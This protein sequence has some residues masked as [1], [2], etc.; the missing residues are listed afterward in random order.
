MWYIDEGC[1]HIEAYSDCC[2]AFRINFFGKIFT[3]TIQEKTPSQN[4]DRNEE[5]KENKGNED[6]RNPSLYAFHFSH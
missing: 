6:A 1:R 5:N 2:E 3:L 4:E